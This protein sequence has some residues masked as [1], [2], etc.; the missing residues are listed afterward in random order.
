MSTAKRIKE[1]IKKN[2][3]SVVEF[4]ERTGLGINTLASAIKRGNE[5]SLD[6]LYKIF[7]SFPEWDKNFILFG[8]EEKPFNGQSHL[9]HDSKIKI[10]YVPNLQ[11]AAG[12]IEATTDGVVYENDLE[13]FTFDNILKPDEYLTWSISGPSMEPV[14]HDGDVV[15]ASEISR[16]EILN[17]VSRKFNE[18]YVYV[19]FTRDEDY[20]CVVK[21]V[22][23]NFTGGM[24]QSINLV[25]QNIDYPEIQISSTKIHSIWV[26]RAI[27]T[28]N[29]PDVM[30]KED[31]MMLANEI[32]LLREEIK[33]LKI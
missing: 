23:R 28:K 27:I 19:V 9:T 32:R 31:Y 4:N 25:S 22:Y 1:L 30:Y 18:G 2:D 7:E 10:K 5:L 16:D 8:D 21:R 24:L 26:I 17:P 33:S 11:A 15:F 20:S 3:L 6:N 14:L 12:Y 29:L 13:P